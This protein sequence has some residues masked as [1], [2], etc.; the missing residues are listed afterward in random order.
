[1]VSWPAIIKYHR[2]DELTYIASEAQWARDPDL[3]EFT[4]EENDAL[5]DHNGRVYMLNKTIND[6]VQPL[7]T[8]NIVT[9]HQL[10]RLVQRHAAVKGECC[11][12]KIGFKN[13][14]DGIALV[15]S[16]NKDD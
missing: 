2:D 9:L 4:Y 13:I 8:Q 12:E 7:A 16:L 1:M 15:A 10:T 3:S 5:I 14:A 11:I 6:V